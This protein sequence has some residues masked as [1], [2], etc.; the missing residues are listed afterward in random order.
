MARAGGGIKAGEYVIRT[1][2]PAKDGFVSITFMFGEM[3]GPYSQRLMNWVH[4][5]GFCDEATRD[6]NWVDFFMMLYV[7][8]SGSSR[9]IKHNK[10]NLRIK[11]AF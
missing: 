7:S 9:T 2:Y 6:L 3:L 8:C 4:E 11:S 1:V 10:C 5:E